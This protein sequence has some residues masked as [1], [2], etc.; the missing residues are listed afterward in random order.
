MN[1]IKWTYYTDGSGSP[2]MGEGGWAWVQVEDGKAVM[3][4]SGHVKMTTNNRMELTA[5]IEAIA[6]TPPHYDV[7]IHTDSELTIKCAEGAYTIRANVDL[8]REF[9]T[10]CRERAGTV[11]FVKVKAHSG[12]EFNNLADKLAG[13]ARKGVTL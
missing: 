4:G 13:S 8:W 1:T 10:L 6:R 12:D 11:N 2:S 3:K 7:E 5:V 9:Q